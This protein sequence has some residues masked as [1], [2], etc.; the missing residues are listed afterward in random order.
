MSKQVKQQSN[1]DSIIERDWTNIQQALKIFQMC[2][3][4]I[5]K[6]RDFEDFTR[7]AI[8]PQKQIIFGE[9]ADYVNK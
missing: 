4:M 6:L 1:D 2:N 5:K 9:N 3:M 8:L 7:K